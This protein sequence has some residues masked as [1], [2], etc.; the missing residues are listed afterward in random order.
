MHGRIQWVLAILAMTGL[1]AMAQAGINLDQVVLALSLD[2]GDGNIATDSSQYGNDGALVGDQAGGG[3]FGWEPGKI[4]TGVRFR[5]ANHIAVANSET[6][7]LSAGNFTMAM[8]FKFEEP[9]GQVPMMDHTNARGAESIGWYLE[10]RGYQFT[11]HVNTAGDDIGWVR[12]NF[13]E[14]VV[15]DQWYHV[16]VT[17][18]GPN[19]AFYLDGNPFGT[20]VEEAPVPDP[21]RINDTLKIAGA[22]LPFFPGMMDEIVISR[23][24]WGPDDVQVHL[25]SGVQGVLAVRPHDKLATTWANVRTGEQR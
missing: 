2:D 5:G 12:S 19:Y 22:A 7:D 14:D 6:L 16:C 15:L 10:F 21:L 18:D 17:K 9:F 11:I 13:H 24:V 4:G 1:A 3:F 20:D 25:A 8:W 23:Q